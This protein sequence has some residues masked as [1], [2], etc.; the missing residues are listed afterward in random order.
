[1]R[2]A[3]FL[4][5]TLSAGALFA[6]AVYGQALSSRTM[7]ALTAEACSRLKSLT[8]PDTTIESAELVAA[9][10]FRSPVPGPGPASNMQLPAHCRVTAWV[11]PTSDSN[12]EVAVWLPATDWNGKFEAVGNGGWAG[13]VSYPAM[14][15]SI[16]DGY[17]TTSTDTG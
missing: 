14:A 8:L 7:P 13:V 1:M 4:V 11:K 15:Q 17:A 6:P 9:G 12:I 5:T 3:L 2:P 10:P 16:F